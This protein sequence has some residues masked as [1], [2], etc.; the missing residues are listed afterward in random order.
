MIMRKILLAAVVVLLLA[1]CAP[2]VVLQTSDPRTAPG[3]APAYPAL[4]GD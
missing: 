4:P 2:R 3:Y 1:A